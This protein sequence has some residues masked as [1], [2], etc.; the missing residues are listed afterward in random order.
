VIDEGHDWSEARRA[1]AEIVARRHRRRRRTRRGAIVALA[2]MVLGF[3]GL[4]VFDRDRSVDQPAPLEP[5]PGVD[6]ECWWLLVA[7]TV[8]SNTAAT[9]PIPDRCLVSATTTPTLVDA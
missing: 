3:S 1:D 6:A 9:A 2:G 5:P 4:I 8:P 7:T